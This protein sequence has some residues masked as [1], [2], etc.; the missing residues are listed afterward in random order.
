VVTKEGSESQVEVLDD[1]GRIEEIARIIGGEK[2]TAQA[3]AFAKKLRD[4]VL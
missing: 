1:T 4:T 3:M 2:P